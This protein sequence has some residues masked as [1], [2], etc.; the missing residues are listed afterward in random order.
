MRGWISVV[1]LFAVLGTASAHLRQRIEI[2]ALDEALS[3][4]RIDRGVGPE[5]FAVLRHDG[6]T[7]NAV[8]LTATDG[9]PVGDPIA[10]FSALGYDGVR[11]LIEAGTPQRL[12]AVALVQP[13]DLT[14]HHIAAGT[15][16]AAHADEAQ[17]DGGP[18]MFAKLVAPTGPRASV[19]ASDRLLDY[20]VEL[21]WVALNDLRPGERASHWGLLLC[22]DYTDRATL[23]RQLDPDDVG[24]GQGFA[25]GKSFD[26]ALPVGELLV[27]PRDARAFAQSLRLQLYVDGSLRQ[28]APYSLA[29]WEIDTIL[30]QAWARRDTRWAHAG[31]QVGLFAQD[32]V[33]PARTL[34]LSGTP[35]GT[36]FKGISTLQKLRGA[37]RWVI[38]GLDG[39]LKDAVIETYITD[40]KAG[41][42]FL[43]PGQNVMIRSDFLGS[44]ENRIVP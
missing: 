4:A 6:E 34:I 9:R 11:A 29:I 10:L 37:W 42:G 12:D 38:G 39:E 2:A 31:R 25:T 26:G 8:P 13:L 1:L 5:V 36:A 33:L 44:V 14:D 19:S 28:D 43:Q 18:F 30:D 41:A 17:V 23:L 20:E 24:S 15:N 35:D 16:F 21:C 7:L 27:I 22:N 32:G 3:L 40:A